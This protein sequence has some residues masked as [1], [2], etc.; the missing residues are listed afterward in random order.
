MERIEKD[1]I[2]RKDAEGRIRNK[3]WK[4]LKWYL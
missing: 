1:E 2:G 3:E 4:G